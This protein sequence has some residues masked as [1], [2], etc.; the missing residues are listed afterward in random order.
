M[1]SK[2]VKTGRKRGANLETLTAKQR[3]FIE[4]YFADRK[5]NGSE[6]ARRAGYASPGEAAYKLMN[7]PAVKAEI[8]KRFSEIMWSHQ[9]DR[10]RI[11]RELTSVAF[12]NPQDFLKPDGGVKS[13]QELPQEVARSISSLSISY[14]EEEGEDGT[15]T[16]IKNVNFKFW[17]KMF[18]LDL[19]M[20][21]LGMYE[22]QKVE[23]TVSV[24]WDSMI[25]PHATGASEGMDEVEA[26]IEHVA[27]TPSDPD[28]T[29]GPPEDYDPDIPAV[30]DVTP[31]KKKKRATKK[32]KTK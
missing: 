11:L 16:H 27:Q 2:T 14:T 28:H 5:M 6:A 25:K 18:A 17:D 3:L 23:H 31:R 13:L 30:K 19:L 15:L 10:E 22:A 29:E 7:T 8:D 21:H 32:R 20:K 1:S 9:A 4:A 12:M 24:D 26:L